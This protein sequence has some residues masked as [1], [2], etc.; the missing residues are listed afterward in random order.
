[1]SSTEEQINKAKNALNAA[2]KQ[3]N[4]VVIR[5]EHDFFK[6]KTNPGQ[7]KRRVWIF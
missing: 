5:Q 7:K 3:E 1:M 2:L 6:S 4:N